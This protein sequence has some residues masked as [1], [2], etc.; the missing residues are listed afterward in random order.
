MDQAKLQAWWS[1]RQALDG[2]LA[3]K[4]AADVL[5]RTGWARSVGGAAPYLT[6]WSRGGIGRKA[7]DGALAATTDPEGPHP[8]GEGIGNTSTGDTD[9]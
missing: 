6:L 7:A 9:L 8:E 3:G 1:H 4:P 2:R 5:R